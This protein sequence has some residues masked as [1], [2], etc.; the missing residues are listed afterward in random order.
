[1]IERGVALLNLADHKRISKYLGT[2]EK[3]KRLHLLDE[4]RKEKVFLPISLVED[5]LCLDISNQE[6]LVLLEITGSSN[7]LLLEDFYTKNLLFWQQDLASASLR[8]WAE[9]TEGTLWYRLL[10]L[11]SS[12]HATQRVRYT[13]LDVAWSGGTEQILKKFLDSEGIEEFSP[14][15]HALLIQRCLQCN[16]YSER[17]FEIV[18][19][20]MKDAKMP[21][22]E[23]K[24]L[25]PAVAYV[26]RFA[27]PDVQK[28]LLSDPGGEV[29][30][31]LFK[32]IGM[33][34]DLLPTH[35]QKLNEFCETNKDQKDT[36]SKLQEIW[37]A[38]W[39]RVELSSSVLA[40]AMETI[41]SEISNPEMSSLESR[42]W[43]FFAGC[44]VQNLEKAVCQIREEKQM[45]SAVKFLRGFLTSPLPEVIMDALKERLTKTKNPAEFLASLNLRTRIDLAANASGK[46]AAAH[47]SL[48]GSLLEEEKTYINLK[49]HDI[50]ENR[51]TPW[52]DKEKNCA[53][54]GFEDGS[55]LEQAV[56][57]RKIFFDVTYRAQDI[58][59]DKV[60]KY[61][62]EEGLWQLL[63]KNWLDPKEESLSILASVSRKAPAIFKL[64]YIN[65]LERF[66]GV[67][68]AA[69]K[70]LDFIRA[71]EE[72]ELRAVVKALGGIGTSRAMQELIACLT[73]PNISVS[74][75]L[76][77]CNLLK[78]KNVKNLQRELRSAIDDLSSSQQKG[79]DDLLELKEALSELLFIPDMAV[80]G[81][82]E[83]SDPQLQAKNE[84]DAGNKKNL[85][86]T[87]TNKIPN[88]KNLSS[89]VRRAL[90]TAQFFDEQVSGSVSI[91][92]I[93][94]APVIDMQYKALELIFRES[95]EEAVTKA[96]HRGMIQRKLDVIGYARPIPAAMDEFEN[97][98]KNLPIVNTIPFFSKF[99]LRK[100][101]RGICQFQPGKRFTLDGIKAF[102]LFFLCFSRKQCRY[103]LQNM[104]PLNF[105]SDEA[106][107][108]FCRALH[109]FQDFRNRA[110]HEGFHPDASNNL[111][112]IWCSTAEIVQNVYRLKEEIR[113]GGEL[114]F[115]TPE[116]KSNPVIMHKAS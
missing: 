58:G 62:N 21:F 36:W 106:L 112:S 44:N 74:L 47:D 43:T 38:L 63:A 113:A 23:N 6:R 80:T 25:L 85:D 100:M 41:A 53:D 5:L 83:Q 87:L 42:A 98:I 102:A 39:H 56:K 14:A 66:V 116:N 109:V 73:R 111:Q 20:I 59:A 57:S 10:P 84:T 15:F 31:D 9:R 34:R 70:I 67:D 11:T 93:D 13:I 104:F 33:H 108:D 24:A 40:F 101:L 90:R 86:E 18:S 68:A 77:I 91:E 1:M 103:G 29:L 97:Y 89:E 115:S 37:P 30:G 48:F 55:P 71:T 50:P 69:L 61:V 28:S 35:I 72:D 54:E 78:T 52:F 79:D 22:P 19:K 49:G 3:V 92:T 12:P 99:K 114:G 27:P 4:M 45:L 60:K 110:A 65:T 46:N 81:G 8:S 2:R 76:E 88:Y 96:I 7:S 107:T 16:I 75:R 82:G 94:L 26:I 64:C 51:L 17:V 105:K 32:I 95:F